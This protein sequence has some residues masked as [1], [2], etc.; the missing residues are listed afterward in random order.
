VFAVT[1]AGR[2]LFVVVAEAMDGRD[3]I[4]TARDMTTSE[5]RLYQRR[6]HRT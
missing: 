3:I 4:V 5:R 2:Y 6:T 1:D